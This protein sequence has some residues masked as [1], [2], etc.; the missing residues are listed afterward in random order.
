MSTCIVLD[1]EKNTTWTDVRKHV[2]QKSGLADLHETNQGTACGTYAMYLKQL[3]SYGCL[4]QK[5]N[6]PDGVA[7]STNVVFVTDSGGDDPA[8]EASTPHFF[9]SLSVLPCLL[10]LYFSIVK[11]PLAFADKLCEKL[12]SKMNAPIKYWST[13]AKTVHCWRDRHKAVFTEWVQAVGVVEADT[14][15]KRMPPQQI[16]GRWDNI[17][18]S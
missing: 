2:M 16:S 7:V 11:W 6:Q 10:H 13:I 3:S 4:L 1:V 17:D 8:K 12:S 14:F 9:L 18:D 5:A 15:A